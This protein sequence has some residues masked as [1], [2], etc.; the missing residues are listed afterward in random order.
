YPNMKELRVQHDGHPYRI[1]FIFD[2]KR[3]AV[4]LIGGD[5]TGNNRWY[6]EFVPKADAIYISYLNETDQSG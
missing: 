5:K 4:L 1:L 6:D 2:P 3:N